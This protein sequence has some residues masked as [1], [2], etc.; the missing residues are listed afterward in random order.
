MAV[1]V[2][3]KAAQSSVTQR[4]TSARGGQS[5]IL[6]ATV[7]CQAQQQGV[8]QDAQISRRDILM[9]TVLSV[10]ATS[11]VFTPALALADEGPGE[12]VTS[13]ASER[14]AST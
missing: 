8:S 14:L 6:R 12:S 4:Q 9:S 1:N 13:W 3:R 11:G 10:A 2:M 7:V 5:R